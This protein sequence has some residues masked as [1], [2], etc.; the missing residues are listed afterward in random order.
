VR[1][2]RRGLG[3]RGIGAQLA[4]LVHRE[5]FDDLDAPVIRGRAPTWPMPYAKN[6]E[7]IA[8]A[9]AAKVSSECGRCCT[10]TRG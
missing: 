6:L 4:Y 10:W 5:A 2:R 7:H 3:V 8:D 9:A 1:D